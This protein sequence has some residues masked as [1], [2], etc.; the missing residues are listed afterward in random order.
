MIDGASQSENRF[1]IDGQDT[2]NLRTGLSGKGLVV[3]FIEQIQVKQSGYNAE[4]RATTG[5]VVSAITKSG[6]NSIHGGVG[7]RLQRQAAERAAG[8]I[9]PGLRLDP[10]VSGS[11][12]P[13]EYFTTPRTSEYERYTVEPIYDIGGPIIKN[14]AWFFFGYNNA[15]FN[16]D[17]T[18]QWPNPVVGGVTYPAIQTFNDE[19][20]RQAVPLQRH[21][22]LA[23]NLRVR[24]NGNNQQRSSAADSAAARLDRDDTFT[25]DDNGNTI[26]I[27]NVN[28][29]TFN[30]RPR[31]HGQGTTTRTAPSSTGTSTTRRTRTSRSATWVRHPAT[32]AA[33]TTTAS[34]GR[35][36][37]RTST[38]STCRRICSTPAATRTTC[39]TRSR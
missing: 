8:D 12:P 19:V 34:A 23:P 33:T 27:S 10:T 24:V 11:N 26:G 37:A 16:Q 36:A 29:A 31:L 21:V 18:V 2:T 25:V 1:V 9:R 6:T 38:T 30:P 17:R 20:D 7:D 22:Q 4:F 15:I 3:D 28:A 32:R 5:G 39:R 14:K 35:S 13:A